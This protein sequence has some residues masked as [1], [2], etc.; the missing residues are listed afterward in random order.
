MTSPSAGDAVEYL[1]STS[2]SHTL[3]SVP[4]VK[5]TT[6]TF[7]ATKTLKAGLKSLIENPKP[8]SPTL[9]Y[10]GQIIEKLDKETSQLFIQALKD[11]R[12]RHVDLLRLCEQE[13]YKMAEAT[14]RR[15]RSRHCRC[16]Q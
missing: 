1:L 7:R 15:H 3:S 6:N 10:I 9:C 14:M 2:Q 11:S 8:L 13:G 12:I 16:E 4:D 5:Q